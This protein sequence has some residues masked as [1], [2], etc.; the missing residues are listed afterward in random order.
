MRSIVQALIVRQLAPA[1]NM[2]PPGFVPL[3]SAA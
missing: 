2:L 3:L 1:W